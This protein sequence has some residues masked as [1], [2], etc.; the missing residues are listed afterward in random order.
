MHR[1]LQVSVGFHIRNQL[2]V[3]HGIRRLQFRQNIA[4]VFSAKDKSPPDILKLRCL[5]I[6]GR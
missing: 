6:E 5:V 3:R 4:V 2:G 1:E